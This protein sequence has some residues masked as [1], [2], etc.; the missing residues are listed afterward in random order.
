M[1]YT[2]EF[3]MRRCIELA[4]NG[5]GYVA[6]NPM[7]GAVITYNG[8]IIGEGYHTH[9]GAPHAEVMAV[10]SV[11]DKSLLKESVIYVNLEP[12]CHYGKTPP[13]AQLI[14]ETGIAKVIIASADPFPS[15][16]GGGIKILKENGITVINGILENEAHELNKFFYTYHQKKRP[17]IILKWAESADGYID[18]NRSPD[19]RP[20][21]ISN[22][23]SRMLT[24]RWR[25]QVQAIM[26]GT[27]TI[28]MDNPQ[29][30]SRNWNNNNPLRVII[31]RQG[32]I[33]PNCL[34]LNNDSDNLLFISHKPDYVY[35]NRTTKIE[36]DFD[37]NTEEKILDELTKRQIQS[38]LIE[39]GTQI[40]NSFMRK[41][42][43]DEARVFVSGTFLSNGIKA[44]QKP[45]FC[46]LTSS[47]IGN[48]KLF[49]FRRNNL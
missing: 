1:Q 13:C 8:H 14:I 47:D 4:R 48:D 22:N 37:K 45:D 34:A 20:A 21:A 12:C 2:N 39:G 9:F 30:T 6:P 26:A 35:S 15:V 40:I 33:S 23:T 10:K 19:I 43:W 41:N 24:H 31:D 46:K 7:V 5:E 36:T 25:S 18:I 29:L 11:K 49:V 28:L 17:Y 16:N 42:L 3:L 44:P 27:N 32:R 38:L